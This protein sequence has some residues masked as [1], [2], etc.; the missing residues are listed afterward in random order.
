M[1]STNKKQLVTAYTKMNNNSLL[2][3]SKN[4]KHMTNFQNPLSFLCAHQK[5]MVPYFLSS[6]HALAAQSVGKWIRLK[7]RQPEFHLMCN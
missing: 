2:K 6:T 7:L 5:R 1:T 4:R 3:S